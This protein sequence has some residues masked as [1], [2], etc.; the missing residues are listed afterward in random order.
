M[1]ERAAYHY[2]TGG[3]KTAPEIEPDGRAAEEVAA[4]WAW[5]RQRANVSTRQRANKEA[6]A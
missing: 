6:A 5:V 4:L 2:A 3:G 1:S